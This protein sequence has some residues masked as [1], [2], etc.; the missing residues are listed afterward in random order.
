MRILKAIIEEQLKNISI[1]DWQLRMEKI[2]TKYGNVWQLIIICWKKVLEND[3][4]ILPLLIPDNLAKQY[5]P[6][7]NKWDNQTKILIE[8]TFLTT[9]ILKPQFLKTHPHE[10]PTTT[11]KKQKFLFLMEYKT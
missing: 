4:E 3:Y 6:T 2:V 5:S 11:S 9:L 8:Q 7:T 1:Q 10:K